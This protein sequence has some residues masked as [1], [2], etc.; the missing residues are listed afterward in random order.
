MSRRTGA[1]RQ[2]VRG[3]LPARHGGR[4][5]VPTVLLPG[6]PVGVGPLGR[7]LRRHAVSA[8]R[9]SFSAASERFTLPSSGAAG[10]NVAGWMC[11][12]PCEIGGRGTSNIRHGP[13]SD[14]P[15]VALPRPV[16]IVGV[17][18]EMRSYVRNNIKVLSAKT[19]IQC[20]AVGA[21]YRWRA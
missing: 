6:V 2:L 20:C 17:L 3:Q 12:E 15:G 4:P 14:R 8:E 13:Y 1:R 7:L 9:T 11:E 21:P 18:A 16:H 5:R 19:Y 10:D